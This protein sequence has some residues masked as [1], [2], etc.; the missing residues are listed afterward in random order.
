MSRQS[1]LLKF[2]HEELEK[3][4]PAAD[5]EQ[6]HQDTKVAAE[7]QIKA[8]TREQDALKA[9]Q[10]KLRAEVSTTASYFYQFAF[11]KAKEEVTSLRGENSLLSRV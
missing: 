3:P 7:K 11:S 5:L 9:S 1:A 4:N 2:F 10:S 8:L 6:K